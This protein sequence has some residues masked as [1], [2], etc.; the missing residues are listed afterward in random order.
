M[1]PIHDWY[2]YFLVSV[3]IFTLIEVLLAQKIVLKILF[4]I[5]IVVNL[6]IY[7]SSIPLPSGQKH[8]V[9]QQ[10]T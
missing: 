2:N 4:T 9:I 1:F 3:F 5:L 6:Y 7:T 10:I 8:I